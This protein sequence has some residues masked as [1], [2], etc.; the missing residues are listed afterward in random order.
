M[1]SFSFLLLLLAFIGT[2]S[3]D[4]FVVNASLPGNALDGQPINA[5]G[6]AFWVGGSPSTYCPTVVGVSCPKCH[7]P[8]RHRCWIQCTECKPV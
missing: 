4:I 5:A 3:A 1:L 6:Q 8:D 2:I 7:C